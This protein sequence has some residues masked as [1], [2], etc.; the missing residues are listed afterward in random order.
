MKP[1]EQKKT[2]TK[3]ERKRMEK[4]MVIKN[5]LKKM[6]KRNKMLSKKNGKGAEKKPDKMQ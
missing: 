1:H 4:Q 5:K 6:R 2:G 3:Q